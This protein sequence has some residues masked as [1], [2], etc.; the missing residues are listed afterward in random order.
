MGAG[1]DP[2][3][4]GFGGGSAPH[5]AQCPLLPTSADRGCWH[6]LELEQPGAMFNHSRGAA[7]FLGVR[8]GGNHFPLAG[9]LAGRRWPLGP[10]P[11]A[12]PDARLTSRAE[13]GTF[14]GEVRALPAIFWGTRTTPKKGTT[15][16]RLCCA[17][18]L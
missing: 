4:A 15:I 10:W 2:G 17:W 14:L 7:W 11:N 6:F 12:G 13:R 8:G 5:F 18:L 3:R 9:G 16:E 1:S